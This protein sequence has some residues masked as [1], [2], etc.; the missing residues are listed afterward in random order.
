[1]TGFIFLLAVSG[2]SQTS[3]AVCCFHAG[4]KSTL[5]VSSGRLI[6]NFTASSDSVLSIPRGTVSVLIV[7]LAFALA[8]P[9]STYLAVK[10]SFSLGDTYASG[11]SLSA[12]ITNLPL[13]L[14]VFTGFRVLASM[15]FRS[16]SF[17]FPD[18]VLTL[19]LVWF[20]LIGWFF[21]VGNSSSAGSF[22]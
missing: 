18:Y 11:Q 16:V 13:I 9:G 14:V 1:M 17:G 3:L 5:F 20:L 21:P 8:L 4:Y 2:C 12:L 6:S 10:H 15:S 22:G 19:N 7:V